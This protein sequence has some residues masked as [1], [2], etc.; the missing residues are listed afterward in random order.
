MLNPDEE[1]EIKVFGIQRDTK[2][3]K[4]VISFRIQKSTDDVVTKTELLQSIAS[5]FDPVEILSPAVASLKIQVFLYENHFFHWA[6]L[7]LT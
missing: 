7:F 6:L 5:I 2:H 4:F 3:D 1:S